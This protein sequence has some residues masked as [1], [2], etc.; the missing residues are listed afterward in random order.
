MKGTKY[1]L[2]SSA[3]ILLERD[4]R[5]TPAHHCARLKLHVKGVNVAQVV[6]FTMGL[7]GW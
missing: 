2:R 6:L 3:I 1:V 5:D 7:K 4:R